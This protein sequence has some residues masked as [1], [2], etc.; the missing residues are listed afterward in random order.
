MEIM[1]LQPQEPRFAEA[2]NVW[3]LCPGIWTLVEY[4][5]MYVVEQPREEL[6]GNLETL[7][8]HIQLEPISPLCFELTEG[9]LQTP[10]KLN[11]R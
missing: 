11:T 5:V 9:R 10:V 8:L 2:V 3:K 1:W 6:D 7:G 4:V